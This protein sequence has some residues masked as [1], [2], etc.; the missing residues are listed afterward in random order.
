MR[1]TRKSLQI[2]S[3]QFKFSQEEDD[4]QLTVAVLPVTEFHSSQLHR[5]LRQKRYQ[6]QGILDS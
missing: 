1:P 3:P 5:V 2:A 6:V 4:G